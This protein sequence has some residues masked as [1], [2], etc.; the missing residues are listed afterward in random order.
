[1][2]HSG[3]YAVV[4][5]C[6]DDGISGIALQ[7]GIWEKSRYSGRVVLQSVWIFDGP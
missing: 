6:A 4:W 7:Y 2:C 1:M 5:I 3:D